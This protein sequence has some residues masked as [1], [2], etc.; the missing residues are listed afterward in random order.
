MND[1]GS[2]YGFDGQKHK[3]ELLG[4]EKYA[5]TILPPVKSG[6]THTSVMLYVQHPII[7]MMMHIKVTTPDQ[8]ELVC[9]ILS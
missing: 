4:Q 6:S 7:I 9:N 8:C 5:Q 2:T 3:R 1:T